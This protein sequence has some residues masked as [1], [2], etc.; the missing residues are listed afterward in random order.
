MTSLR[1]GTGAVDGNFTLTFKSDPPTR[2]A[3]VTTAGRSEE[4]VLA[5]MVTAL[6]GI[7]IVSQVANVCS[8]G[9][10][11]SPLSWAPDM[12]SPT[13][14]ALVITGLSSR[15]SQPQPEFKAVAPAG[16]MISVEGAGEFALQP[17]AV[18]KTPALSTWGVAA[19][20]GLLLLAGA[21]ILRRTTTMN[22]SPR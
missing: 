6:S 8:A 20:V 11:G 15:G 13:P 22:L 9:G 17:E 16:W 12:H 14:L 19:L 1:K 3:T 4:Q 10:P 21:W 18:K 2:S 7:G 5:A